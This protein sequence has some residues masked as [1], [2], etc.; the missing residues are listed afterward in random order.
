MTR[1]TDDELETALQRAAWLREHD[2]DNHF[3]GKALLNH[4]HRLRL[5]DHVLQAAKLYLHSGDGAR[6]HTDL[7]KAI[8][9]AEN[10]ESR[11][12]D[13]PHSQNQGVIL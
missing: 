9:E 8:E 1:P 12:G 4:D 11:P 3:V 2:Q 7:L 10:A 5:L 6:E 13:D